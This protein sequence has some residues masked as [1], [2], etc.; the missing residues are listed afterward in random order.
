MDNRSIFR[1]LVF[2]A[3]VVAAAAAI[4]AGAYNA[5]VARGIAQS[6]ALTA[7]PAG[8]PYPVYPY[9]WYRPWGF[10]FFPFLLMLLPFFIIA[11]ILVW[12]GRWHGLI[13][14]SKPHQEVAAALKCLSLDLPA[15]LIHS[16]AGELADQMPG[17]ALRCSEG[18]RTE[19]VAG[20]DRGKHPQWSDC[21]S[22]GSSSAIG[23][24]KHGLAQSEPIRHARRQR[25]E[26]ESEERAVS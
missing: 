12:R 24:G 23:H 15:Q 21:S 11:R 18:H 1:A 6:A 20:D 26:G 5:G 7:P 13:G 4:G 2:G 22:K 16:R 8:V 9:M 17:P 3:L 14:G 19:A 10:G 25:S